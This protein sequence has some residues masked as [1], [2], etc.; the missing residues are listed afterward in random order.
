[1]RPVRH[2]PM[3]RAAL[4]REPRPDNSIRRMGANATKI[5]EKGG[6][7]AAALKMVRANKG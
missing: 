5:P 4:S 7:P 3:P 6:P 2:S 1:M